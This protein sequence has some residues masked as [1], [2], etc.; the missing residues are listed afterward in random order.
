MNLLHINYGCLTATRVGRIVV[1][2]P[3][4]VLYISLKTTFAKPV[5]EFSGRLFGWSTDQS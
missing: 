5:L 2:K 4:I 3:K 1:T